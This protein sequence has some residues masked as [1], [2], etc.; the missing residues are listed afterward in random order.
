MVRWFH[1]VL[2]LWLK[3]VALRVDRVDVGTDDV[4][5][6]ILD[7]APLGHMKSMIF[8][9]GRL[10][11]DR[12]KIIVDDTIGPSS[13][14]QAFDFVQRSAPPVAIWVVNLKNGGNEGHLGSLELGF[15]S[16][17]NVTRHGVFHWA[18]E[19]CSAQGVPW[20]RVQQMYE[21]VSFVFQFAYQDENLAVLDAEKYMPWPLGPA[22][23]KGWSSNL[24]VSPT[25]QRQI[26]ASFRGSTNTHQGL[27][28]FAKDA[29]QL[30]G[31]IV[32]TNGEWVGHNSLPDVN[33]YTELMSTSKYAFNFAGHNPNCFRVVE[34]VE[35]G[36]VPILF[37][38][39]HLGTCH[40]NWAA[41]YGFPNGTKYGWIPQAPFAVFTSWDD[42]TSSVDI[43]NTTAEEKGSRLAPWYGKWRAAFARQFEKKFAALLG[44]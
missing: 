7:R 43:L 32:E 18:P 20:E 11:Q 29:S 41:L 10:P 5:V 22:W 40:S 35:S 33:R 23:W 3:V 26:L 19:L 14:H 16:T 6:F 34:A 31:L 30:P 37:L 25:G 13:I 21:S 38:Q 36:A 44:S 28:V 39:P 42:M 4:P 1:V 27:D 24:S 12:F 15:R 9:W 2:S 8:D 17:S